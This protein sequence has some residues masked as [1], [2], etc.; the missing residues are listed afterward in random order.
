MN[1]ATQT[2]LASRRA[3]GDCTLSC[4]EDSWTV[5]DKLASSVTAA[6]AWGLVLY[7]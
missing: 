7:D 2:L 1:T 3:G 5:D 4:S 6:C